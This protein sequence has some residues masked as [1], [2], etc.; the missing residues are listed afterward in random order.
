MRTNLPSLF[1]LAVLALPT[2]VFG[3]QT[4]MG[5]QSAQPIQIVLY[6]APEPRPALKYQLLP[7]FPDRRPGNA[8]VRWNAI[9]AE[10]RAYV[11]EYWEHVE[12]ITKWMEIPL[13]DPREKAARE[14]QLKGHITISSLI[15]PGLFRRMEQAARLESCNW[16]LPI[17]EGRVTQIL[18]PEF[19]QTGMFARLLAAKAHLEIAQG[20]YG[21]AVRTLQTGYALARHAGQG[22]FFVCAVIGLTHA[23]RM[24]E[25]VQQLIQRPDAPNLYWALS[26]LPRPLVDFQSAVEAES[27]LLYLQ[28]PEL[29]DVDKKKLSPAGWSDLLTFIAEAIR[30][31]NK[32]YVGYSSTAHLK[33]LQFSLP[34]TMSE[35]LR[36]HPDA[37]RYVVERGHTA[38]EV[39]AMPVAQVILLYS[40]G[41]YDELSDNVFKWLFLPASEAGKKP[42]RAERQL[43]DALTAKREIIPLAATLLWR[44][45]ATKDVETQSQW[46]IAVLRVFEAM[47][48]Y[49]AGHQDRWPE[50]L[51]DITEVPVPMNPYDGKPFVYQRKGDKAIVTCSERGPV[52]VPWRYEVTLKQKPAS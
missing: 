26:A 38:A 27:N 8:A 2:T 34:A 10:Q 47:R 29:R 42:E 52:N 44:G 36:D 19:Q 1:V 18:L 11:E 25:Q 12:E 3:Q 40:V 51:T 21:E 7:P 43:E 35:L 28:F 23:R 37:K 22:G 14:K 30:E 17:H 5:G 13:D 41:I 46:Q 9:P 39:E 48:L 49:A 24:S 16:E 31:Y 20:K 6:P 50:R 45:V 4:P 15:Y 33:L 32:K